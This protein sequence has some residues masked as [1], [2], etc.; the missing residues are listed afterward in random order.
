MNSPLRQER[1]RSDLHSHPV[2]CVAE[3]RIRLLTN[4][5]A[6]AAEILNL[7]FP[8]CQD[9]FNLLFK[10]L[11]PKYLQSTKVALWQPR[12]SSQRAGE[13]PVNGYLI[14]S[15]PRFANLASTKGEV[16]NIIMIM[17]S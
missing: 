5:K 3:L 17:E 15:E 7:L 6:T 11:I 10:M 2:V 4:V 14:H 13:Y 12:T 16:A 1:R 8:V 9:I